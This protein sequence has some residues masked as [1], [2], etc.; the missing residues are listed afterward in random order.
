MEKWG[1]LSRASI[2]SII[3]MSH[4]VP[5]EIKN[6]QDYSSIPLLVRIDNTISTEIIYHRGT[7]YND[8]TLMI[9]ALLAIYL[10]ILPEGYFGFSLAIGVHQSV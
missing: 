2:Q 8:F 10:G 9:R 3:K 4:R 7:R 5:K 1:I 6:N